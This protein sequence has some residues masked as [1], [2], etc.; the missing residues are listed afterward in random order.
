MFSGGGEGKRR[1]DELPVTAFSRYA[2]VFRHHPA[3]DHRQDRPAFDFPAVIR[4]I[5]IYIVHLLNINGLFFF[6]VNYDD[7]GV[8]AH[9][10]RSLARIEAENPGRIFGLY[11]RKGSLQVGSDADLIFLDP[12]LPV[13]ISSRNMHSKADF[14]VFE[15]KQIIGAPVFVMQR[16]EVLIENGQ[17]KR[18]QG[19]AKY[20]AGDRNLAAY[21]KNGYPIS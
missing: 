6:R 8:G 3:P 9:L 10:Q 4:A 5:R 17:M 11:P 12:T 20:L 18:K 21:A 7:V 15:G 13:T 14:T 2:S 16:G 1:R 19:R